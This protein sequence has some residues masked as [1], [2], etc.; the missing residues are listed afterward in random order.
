MI[1]ETDE[2][3]K[4]LTD[5]AKLWPELAGQRADLLRKV[6]EVG[7]GAIQT[8]AFE[9]TKSRLAKVEKLAG[10]MDGVWPANWRQELAEDW[11]K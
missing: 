1:T 9:K 8:E 2:L 5:A 10:S 7:I 6:L 11:P 4:A 3:S